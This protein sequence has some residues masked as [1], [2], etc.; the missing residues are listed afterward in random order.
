M[1]QYKNIPDF[2]SL[3]PVAG[4][5]QGCAWGFFRTSDSANWKD[6]DKDG[7]KDVHGCLNLLT[8][9]VIKEAYKEARDGV[10]FSLNYP[11]DFMRMY[12]PRQPT[13]HKVITWREDL[14]MGNALILDDAIS[15]N[16]QSSTQ[17]DSLLHFGHQATDCFYHGTKVTKEQLMRD[18][19]AYDPEKALPTLDHWHDRGGLVGRGILLD[20]RAYAQ[21]KGIEYTPFSRHVITTADLEAVAAHQGTEFRQGDILFVRSGFDED[22]AP[23][24]GEQQNAKMTQGGWAAIGIEGTEATAKWFWNKHFSAV[25][26][27]MLG[28]EVY[29]PVNSDGKPDPGAHLV[30]HQWF[31]AMF[32]LPIGEHFKL[33]ELAEYCAKVGRYSFLLTSVPMNVPG[34]IG[35]PPNAL[36][37]MVEEIV[38]SET[39][40][41]TVQPGHAMT[42]VEPPEPISAMLHS[43]S[44]GPERLQRGRRLGHRLGE[45]RSTAFDTCVL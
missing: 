8:P 30:L 35:S 3:P 7:K 28:F 12:S 44:P 9:E 37:L 43:G 4:M 1:S 41:I 34:L 14:K 2:D 38:S 31:L 18:S 32:G 11:M 5:P 15:F 21:A 36:A 19:R 10:S 33:D 45:T 20:Y 27:D 17:W 22:L 42:E 26:G 13:E 40:Y 25:A 29:P 24:D 16:T 6:S 39:D 23:L